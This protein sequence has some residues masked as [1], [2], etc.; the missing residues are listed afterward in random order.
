MPAPWMKTTTGRAGSK[1]RPPVPAATRLPSRR[2]SIPLLRRPRQRFLGRAQRLAEIG[3]D[4]LGILETDRE[5]DHVLADAGC[6]ELLGAHL[7]MGGAGGV[8][9]QGLGVAHIGEVRDE[10]QRIDEALAGGA[11]AF[12]AEAH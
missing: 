3:Q 8:D 10:L 2:S 6:L 4:V 5:A 9:D 12:D 1:G 7:L 11:A